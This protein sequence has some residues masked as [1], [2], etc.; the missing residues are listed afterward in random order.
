MQ[1]FHVYWRTGI[2]EVMRKNG[3]LTESFSPRMS[4]MSEQ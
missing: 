2:G 4:K 1:C 3:L